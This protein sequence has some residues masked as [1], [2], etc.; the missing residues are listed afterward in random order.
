MVGSAARTKTVGQP[1]SPGCHVG[2]RLVSF[3]TFPCL[4]YFRDTL[5]ATAVYLGSVSFALT[6]PLQS[7]RGKKK[8]WHLTPYPATGMSLLRCQVVFF[9]FLMSSLIPGCSKTKVQIA[10]RGMIQYSNAKE[11]HPCPNSFLFV[12]QSML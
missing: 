9:F 6:A 7:E 2:L 5:P 10:L 4:G 11:L 8:C 1:C 12:A 3:R